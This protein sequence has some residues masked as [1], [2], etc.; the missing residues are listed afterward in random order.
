MP[1]RLTPEDLARRYPR[2]YHMAE[3]GSWASI[4]EHGLLSTA[5]LLDLF[6]VPADQRYALEAQRRAESVPIHHPVHGTAWIR[7]N[8]PINERVLQRTLEGMTEEEFYRTLNSRVFFGVSTGRLDRLRNAPPYRDR[9]H[10][11]LELDTAALVER[12][13]ERVELSHINSG[14]VHP[15]A[16]YP[17]GAGTFAPIE[18]YRYG[19]RKLVSNEP[20]VEA[21]VCT[22]CQTF[23]TSS[24]TSPRVNARPTRSPSADRLGDLHPVAGTADR[25][26]GKSASRSAAATWKRST[27]WGKPRNR[28][29]PR[30]LRLTPPRSGSPTA[31]RACSGQHDLAAVRREA[32]ARGGV[33]RDADVAG[34][35]ERGT[36]AMQADSQPHIDPAGPLGGVHRPLDRQRGLDSAAGACSNTANRSSPRASTS[37]PPA[38]LTAARTRRRT[39]AIRRGYLIAQAPEQLG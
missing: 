17:R 39:S 15:A 12:H 24:S 10:D 33:D 6:E 4:Q 2:L 28:Q 23:A 13:R 18:S 20:L 37:R 27:G 21:T 1:E 35:G 29:A 31:R 16:N 3:E 22:R 14:A 5:A 8:K 32:D 26:G 19:E 11:I 38:D 34:V 30:L 25:G 9:R 7:Y 36:P